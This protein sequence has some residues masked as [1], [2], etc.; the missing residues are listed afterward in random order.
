MTEEVLFYL[1]LMGFIMVSLILN[2]KNQEKIKI[3]ERDMKNVKTDLYAIYIKKV[4][5]KTLKSKTT[6][7]PTAK[8]PV[9]KNTPKRKPNTN[10]KQILKG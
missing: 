4:K 1:M 5:E 3:L 8:K 6:N 2:H 7:K 10:K 9:R